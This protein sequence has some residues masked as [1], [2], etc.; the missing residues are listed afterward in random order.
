MWSHLGGI[1]SENVFESLGTEIYMYFSH[2]ADPL[3]PGKEAY[4]T[5]F[6]CQRAG[7]G[8]LWNMGAS[9]SHIWEELIDKSGNV[10]KEEAAIRGQ[11]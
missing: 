11:K 8:K 10:M 3:C 1:F 4:F 9:Q 5:I 6:H 7:S 2:L